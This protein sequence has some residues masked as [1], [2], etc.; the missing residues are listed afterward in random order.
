MRSGRGLFS[1]I[2]LIF[3]FFAAT[4]AWSQPDTGSATAVDSASKSVQVGC[5]S[6][7]GDS[8]S[9]DR[10]GRATFLSVT[11]PG[12]DAPVSLITYKLEFILSNLGLKRSQLRETFAGKKVLLVGEGFGE[13][14]PALLDAGADVQAVDPL[15][16]FVGHSD[17]SL[18]GVD[19]SNVT[20]LEHIRSFLYRYNS[21]LHAGVADQLPF[22]D[23]TFDFHITHL[24]YNNFITASGNVDTLAILEA[25]H[26]SIRVLKKG[27][28]SLSVLNNGISMLA[29]VADDLE[30]L[31]NRELLTGFSVD[32]LGARQ[33]AM[34]TANGSNIEKMRGH[35]LNLAR[36]RIVK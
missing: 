19:P 30:V 8:V 13:L 31:E 4:T 9:V 15:Y 21:L 7:L 10:F 5:A 12:Q 3:G 22:A 29:R 33:T 26:E 16:A 36:L 2:F 32:N 11:V 18:E 20:M 1:A 28:Q 17:F 34:R 27:G 25:V 14:L 35:V 6:L 23:D 24:V